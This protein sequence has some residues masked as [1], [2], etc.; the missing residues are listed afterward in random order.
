MAKPRY[1]YQSPWKQGEDESIAYWFST[2]DWGG[3]LSTPPTEAT[4]VIKNEDGD[5]VSDENLDGE[6]IIDGINI[7]TPNVHSLI[8][9][10]EYRLEVLFTI[11]T[12][13]YE[14][15]GVIKAEE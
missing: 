13:I 3:S 1:F 10:T 9:D 6:C 4:A 12:N 2:E 14:A 8:R 11:G 15:A 7:A 5:D